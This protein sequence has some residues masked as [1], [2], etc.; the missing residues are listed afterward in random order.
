MPSACKYGLYTMG[1][2]SRFAA[3]GFIVRWYA[4][5]RRATVLFGTFCVFFFSGAR[6]PRAKGI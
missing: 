3:L 2:Y 4:T 1:V 6:I 5:K